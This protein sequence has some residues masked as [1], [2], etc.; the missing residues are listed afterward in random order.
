MRDTI[1]KTVEAFGAAVRQRR[2]EK[3]LTQ[4]ELADLVGVERKWVVRLEAGN[5]SAELGNVFK[6]MKALDLDLEMLEAGSRP[7]PPPGSTL[8]PA[9]AEVLER[10]EQKSDFAGSNGNDGMSEVLGDT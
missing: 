5:S 8:T 10:F 4:V 6:A 7:T 9:T 1:V 2:L 3:G